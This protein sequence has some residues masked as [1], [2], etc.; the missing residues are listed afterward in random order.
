MFYA[1]L[2][3]GY[4]MTTTS[5]MSS[6]RLT[7]FSNKR[8]AFSDSTKNLFCNTACAASGGSLALATATRAGGRATCS[9]AAG[10][11]AVKS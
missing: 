3:H 2:R 9:A 1:V 10:R 11:A 4:K 7:T 5:I 8:P 6:R